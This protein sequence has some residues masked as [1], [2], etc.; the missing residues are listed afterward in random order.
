M[1]I[2]AIATKLFFNSELSEALFSKKKLCSYFYILLCFDVLTFYSFLM[3]MPSI[4]AKTFNMA[5]TE[6]GEIQYGDA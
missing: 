6:F 4:V 3:K 2:F 1:N 5:P